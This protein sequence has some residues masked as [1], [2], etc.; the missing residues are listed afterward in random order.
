MAELSTDQKFINKNYNGSDIRNARVT[1]EQRDQRSGRDNRRMTVRRDTPFDAD[2]TPTPQPRSTQRSY[3]TP[4]SAEDQIT[5]QQN[6]KQK[7]GQGLGSGPN[8]AKLK[9]AKK[10]ALIISPWLLGWWSF[11]WGCIQVWA[12][13]A[14]LIFL[15]ASFVVSDSWFWDTVNKVWAFVVT[16][17]LG[18]QSPD[19]MTLCLIATGVSFGI[20]FMNIGITWLVYKLARIESIYGKTG[21]SLKFALVM[22]VLI[23]GLPGLSLIPTYWLWIWAVTKYPQ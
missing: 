18:F 21:A 23:G 9:A 7:T 2:A 8:Y 17:L 4:P 13:L 20:S 19:V 12:S 16:D 14:A 3:Y 5:S 6:Q 22:L 1:R 15:G 11:W 10:R